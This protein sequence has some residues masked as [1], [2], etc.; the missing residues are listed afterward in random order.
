MRTEFAPSCPVSLFMAGN[1]ELAR[2]VCRKHCDEVGLCVTVTPTAY[3]YTGG[4]EFGFVVG[5]INYPRFPNEP[6]LI[7]AKAIELGMRLREALGQ[8][9]FSVQTPTTTTWFSW[10]DADC[11]S[12]GTATAAANG[13]LPVPQD[14]QARA[15]GIA[16][17]DTP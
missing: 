11:D 15:E 12:D 17:K 7:E 6:A 5:F 9:S 10:R 4:E 1:I 13:D 3:V 8:E 16:Q 2:A 14:C